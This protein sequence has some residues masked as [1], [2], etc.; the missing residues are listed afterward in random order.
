MNWNA[1]QNAAK[2]NGKIDV[3]YK[4]PPHQRNNLPVNIQAALQEGKQSGLLPDFPFG[5]DFTDDELVIA[6]ALARLKALSE[7]PLEMLVALIKLLLGQL[8]GSQAHPQAYLQ[9]MGMS[10]ARTLKDRLLRALFVA[11]L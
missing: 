7:R 9:R 6:R 5:T 11:F 4:I 10:E 2:A 1:V 8:R 3:A